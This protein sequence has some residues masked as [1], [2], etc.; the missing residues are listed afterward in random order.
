MQKERKNLLRKKTN[1][2]HQLACA[3]N[4]QGSNTARRQ[5]PRCDARRNG[6][7]RTV[8]AWPPRPTTSST[9]SLGQ[10]DRRHH[11]RTLATG[12][13]NPKSNATT[14]HLRATRMWKHLPLDDD[15]S[16]RSIHPKRKRTYGS[17][18]H[19][20]TQSSP[21]ITGGD[22]LETAFTYLFLTE[23]IRRRQGSYRKQRR[24]ALED[25]RRQNPYAPRP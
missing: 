10:N 17:I 2:S 9:L 7:T 22:R 3:I 13:R 18:C 6:P 4:P 8:N 25:L 23:S 15:A 21:C 12:T 1:I 5:I 20:K 14:R 16:P 11:I 24:N 19:N